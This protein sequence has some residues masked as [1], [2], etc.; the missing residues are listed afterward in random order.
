MVAPKEGQNRP[1][2]ELHQVHSGIAHIKAIAHG[3]VWWPELNRQIEEMM[4]SCIHLSDNEEC[5]TRG[6]TLA[7]E[8]LLCPG[9]E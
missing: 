5:T 3:Y 9:R 7:M 4:K 6:I 1:L 8:G 2:D